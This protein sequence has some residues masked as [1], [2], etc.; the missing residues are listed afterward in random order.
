MLMSVAE[1]D[2]GLLHRLAGLVRVR[3]A[4]DVQTELGEHATGKPVAPVWPER[5]PSPANTPAESEDTAEH[6]TETEHECSATN[7]QEDESLSPQEPAVHA[8]YG[9]AT[10]AAGD[11]AETEEHLHVGLDRLTRRHPLHDDVHEKAGVA[12]GREEVEGQEAPEERRPVGRV[13]EDAVNSRLVRDA[14]IHEKVA[15]GH[16]RHA[17]QKPAQNRHTT[18]LLGS[19]APVHFITILM[20]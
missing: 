15:H 19:L 7:E 1:A 5:D 16:E 4:F 12:R 17:A 3:A 2:R 9:H 6:T 18:S 10:E 20:V 11:R 13:T 14:I 8:G